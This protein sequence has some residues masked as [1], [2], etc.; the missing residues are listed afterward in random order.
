MNCLVKITASVF[1]LALATRAMAG[2]SATPNFQREIAPLLKNRCVRCHGPATTEAKLNLAVPSGVVR[3]GETGR[4]IVAGKPEKSLLWQ[5]VAADEMPEDDP[6]PADEK[7]LL[8]RWIE[9][10][11]PGLPT[12][13][14]E[15]PDGDEHWAFQILRPV[16]PPVI[17]DASRAAHGRG[18]L[19]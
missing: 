19:H 9:A 8:R 6:L 14:T 12:S 5:R 17:R 16:S 3:G 4:A 1:W 7:D 2:N 18:R 15:H 11:V 13:V 10:G